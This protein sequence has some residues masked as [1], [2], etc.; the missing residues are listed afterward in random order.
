MG[1][2]LQR[3][4]QLAGRLVDGSA[5]AEGRLSIIQASVDLSVPRSVLEALTSSSFFPVPGASAIFSV[6]PGTFV[7]VL[8]QPRILTLPRSWDCGRR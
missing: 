5:G 6:P 4:V 7:P 1:V 2:P 3:W 8:S